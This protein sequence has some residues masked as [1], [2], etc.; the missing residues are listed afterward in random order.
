VGKDVG[1]ENVVPPPGE[2][3]QLNFDLMSGSS[4]LI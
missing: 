1:K 4:P 3:N 2:F